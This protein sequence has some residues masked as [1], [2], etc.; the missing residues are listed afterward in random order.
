[1]WNLDREQLKNLQVSR[2]FKCNSV[3]SHTSPIT[4]CW[5]CKKK[6][7][8]NHIFGGQINKG[9]KKNNCIRDICDECKKE[10]NYYLISEFEVANL[11]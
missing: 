11:E 3:R 4:K 9:M 8:Y 5:E 6:F 7:C 10:K 2:C 1:M